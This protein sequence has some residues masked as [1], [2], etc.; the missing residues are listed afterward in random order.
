[1]ATKEQ[2][3]QVMSADLAK[4]DAYEVERKA[5]IANSIAKPTGWVER[6]AIFVHN[7]Y[8][9]RHQENHELAVDV[10]ND[11]KMLWA[12]ERSDDL[13]VVACAI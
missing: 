12:L 7:A 9:Q 6:C 8:W 13:K 11:S 2:L 4:R 5:K 1:M 10:L 3:I